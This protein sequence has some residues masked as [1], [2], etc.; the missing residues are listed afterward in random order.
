MVKAL[1]KSFGLGRNFSNPREEIQ[2]LIKEVGSQEEAFDDHEK[3]LLNNI[4][5]LRAITASDIMVIKSF[6]KETLRNIINLEKFMLLKLAK[7]FKLF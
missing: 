7:S 5:G 2:D 1:L 4:L 3:I 6:K